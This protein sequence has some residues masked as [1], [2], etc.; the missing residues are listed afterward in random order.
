MKRIKTIPIL[1]MMLS[2]AAASAH[3]FTMT[4]DGQKLY[5]NIRSD[6]NKTVELTYKGSIADNT[7]TCFAGELTVP[8]KVRHNEIV[9]TVT[10]ISPKAFS[11]AD[12]LTG[13][14][15]PSSIKY[16][17][18]F[19]FEGCT[20]L[21]KVIFPGTEVKF[22]DGV[23]F[24]CDKIRSLG[25]GS[26]WKHIDFKMFRWSDSL[27]VVNIP[28]KVEQIRNI[29]S[30]KHLECIKVDDNNA[31]YA[32]VDGILYD[33][34]LVTLYACPRALKGKVKI[35]PDT[36]KVYAGAFYD[37]NSVVIMDVPESLESISF[38]EFSRMT[39]LKEIV[40]RSATPVL[41]ATFYGARCMLFQVAN[42]DVKIIVPKKALPAYRSAIATRAGE[43]SEIGDRMPYVVHQDELPEL[44]DLV[45]VKN[46]VKYDK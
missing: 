9:Y 38:R 45:G 5:F 31:K 40:L 4:V 28:A 46:F 19:A 12:S 13:I 27:K 18:D 14:I 7:P 30:L 26:D 24:K 29:K 25:F 37:C 15:L 23:F 2:G 8:E 36:K 33:K 34:E 39:A 1:L 17:G 10:A 32:S 16:I 43:Y 35:S 42:P 11:N 44:S 6:K 20:S 22:G 21:S 41:T 3:D